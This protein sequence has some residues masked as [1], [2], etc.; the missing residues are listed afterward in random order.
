MFDALYAASVVDYV[1]T[2]VK[3]AP[4]ELRVEDSASS[5]LARL[6]DHIEH[7]RIPDPD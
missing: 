1:N 7:G 4:R 5:D 2:I 6:L 3:L